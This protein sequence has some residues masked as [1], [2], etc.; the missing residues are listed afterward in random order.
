MDGKP[1]FVTRMPCCA[2]FG[3]RVVKHRC[4]ILVRVCHH[5]ADSPGQG[6]DVPSLQEAG[7]LLKGPIILSTACMHYTWSCLQCC[8]FDVVTELA[9]LVLMRMG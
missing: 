7:V 2:G 4:T 5:P 8:E 9:P 1:P 3:L 6:A